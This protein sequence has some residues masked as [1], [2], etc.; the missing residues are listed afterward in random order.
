[1]KVEVHINRDQEVLLRLSE[2]RKALAEAHFIA[3][4]RTILPEESRSPLPPNVQPDA[5]SPLDTLDTYLKLRDIPDER[6]ERLLAVAT[7]IIE[8]TEAVGV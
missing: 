6:R 7:E 8:E 4:I 3:G 1:M 2:A 5:S